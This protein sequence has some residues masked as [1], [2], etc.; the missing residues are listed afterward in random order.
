MYC[1]RAPPRR[2]RKLSCLS[3][4]T[5][6]GSTARFGR[7]LFSTWA[8]IYST[9][10]DANDF[11]R[12]PTLYGPFHAKLSCVCTQKVT[13]QWVI[14][15]NTAVHEA[16]C[17]FGIHFWPGNTVTISVDG[18]NSLSGGLHYFNQHCC[19]AFCVQNTF[20]ARVWI[21]I[22]VNGGTAFHYADASD[23]SN[24]EDSI[25]QMRI[26]DQ[27]RWISRKTKGAKIT[28]TGGPWYCEA[29]VT[30]GGCIKFCCWGG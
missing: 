2:V 28:Q 8:L 17:A 11:S 12:N 6:E 21:E 23:R 15:A 9:Y 5:D 24:F 19:E 4:I 20:S 10:R 1:I 18:G 26:N 7:R 14:P 22:S 3:W 27:K 29:V 25:Q 30:V 13:F 16:F